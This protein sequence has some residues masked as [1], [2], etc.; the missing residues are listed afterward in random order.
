MTATIKCASLPKPPLPATKE[1]RYIEPR[2]ACAFNAY[3]WDPEKGEKARARSVEVRQ[4][5]A[6]ER[7][8]KAK[9]RGKEGREWTKPR[10]VYT[11][12]EIADIKRMRAAGVIWKDIGD[13]YGVTDS[14]IQHAYR[15]S[16]RGQN[17][18]EKR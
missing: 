17:E 13:K 11:P 3:E 8:E 5:R 4:K 12:E 10:R 9:K 2:S 16:K 7:A 6:R 14:A 15:R 1:Y 18:R